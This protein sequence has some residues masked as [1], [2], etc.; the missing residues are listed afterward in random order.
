[1]EVAA[2]YSLPNGAEFSIS[3]CMV[4]VVSDPDFASLRD[5]IA[6]SPMGAASASESLVA[7]KRSIAGL[8]GEELRFCAAE[9]GRV[10]LHAVWRYSGVAH[11]LLRPEIEVEY[12][13]GLVEREEHA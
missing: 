1:E 9:D 11:D 7:E 8:L 10:R 13:S 6:A 4:A 12:S 2:S 3:T 5:A